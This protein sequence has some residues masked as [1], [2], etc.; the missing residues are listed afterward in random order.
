VFREGSGKAVR[1]RFR[2]VPG[3]AWETC[4]PGG[5]PGGGPEAG[6]GGTRETWFRR[7]VRE[8]VREGVRRPVPEVPGKPGS[9]GWSGIKLEGGKIIKKL[10]F[11]GKIIK[12]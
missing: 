3:E 9:G 10:S 8:V 5:G 4:V 6:S 12:S 7:L 1:S 11:G 2:A